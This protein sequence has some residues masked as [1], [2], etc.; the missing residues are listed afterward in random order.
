MTVSRPKSARWAWPAWSI[1]M[2]TLKGR[3]SNIEGR[4]QPSKTYS[5]EITVAHPLVMNVDQPS[6]G[7]SQLNVLYD[8]Q[9]VCGEDSKTSSERPTSSI[10][11]TFGCT[12][13]KSLTFPFT[14]QSDTTAKWFSDIVTP[15]N[16]STFGCRRVF[17]VTTSLQN[18]YK[19]FC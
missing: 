18:L 11:F 12:F 3:L 16:G 5:L 7:V 1:R 14:I 9:L 8:R 19:G 4:L 6:S 2:L 15:I 17:H 13:T 10:R